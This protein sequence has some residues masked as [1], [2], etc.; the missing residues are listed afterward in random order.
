MKYTSANDFLDAPHKRLALI[1]PSGVGKTTVSRLLPSTEWFHFNVDYRIWTHQLGDQ[2]SDFL[3]LQAINHPILGP[4][5]KNDA[6]TLEPRVHIDN[7]LATSHYMGML[8]DPARGGTP[9]GEFIS[10][11]QEYIAAERAAMLDIPQFINRAHTLYDYDHFLVDASGSICEIL[12][13]DLSSDPIATMLASEF[14]VVYIKPTSEHINELTRRAKLDPKPICYRPDFIAKHLPTLLEHFKLSQIE[15]ADPREVGTWLYPKL[16]EER[17]VR[18]QRITDTLGYTIT[19]DEIAS[20]KTADE[21]L[22]IIGEA[23]SRSISAK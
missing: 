16:I 10:R 15:A 21:L 17:L 8:G 20:V 13:S 12:D 5:L 7:L 1:G 2:L 6:I 9:E 22:A 4:L 23:I 18:Y 3:K 11:M 14:A 19:M